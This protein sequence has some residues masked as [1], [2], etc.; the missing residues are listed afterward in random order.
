MSDG[1]VLSADSEYW[2]EIPEAWKRLPAL[3][4]KTREFDSLC[5]NEAEEE[6]LP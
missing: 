1:L 4:K 6:T 2:E 3:P 5:K